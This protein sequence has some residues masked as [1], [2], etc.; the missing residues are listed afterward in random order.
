MSQEITSES[1]AHFIDLYKMALGDD[2]FGVI[3]LQMLYLFAEERGVPKGELDKLLQSPVDQG[4]QIPPDLNRRI[5]Y[6]Y[7]LAAMILFDNVVTEDERN[8]LKKFCQKFEFLDENID[9]LTDYLLECVKDGT[10]IT[11]IITQLNS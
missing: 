4:L 1:K 5:T 2:S 8:T 6:L 10:T 9:G 7:D 3:E 11:Q